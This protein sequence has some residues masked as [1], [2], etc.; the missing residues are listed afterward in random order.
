[1]ADEVLH[2]NLAN[3]LSDVITPGLQIIALVV[4]EK[5]SPHLRELFDRPVVVDL[6]RED[7]AILDVDL[8]FGTSPHALQN[9]PERCMFQREQMVEERVGAAEG[10]EPS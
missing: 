8:H 7:A 10:V 1:M 9:S 5:L 6:D 2:P 3:P 4:S